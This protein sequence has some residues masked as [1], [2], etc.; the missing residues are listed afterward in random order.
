MNRT[1][2]LTGLAKFPII[3]EHPAVAG[4][5]L[6]EGQIWQQDAFLLHTDGAAGLKLARGLRAER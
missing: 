5:T 2:R 1:L 4:V 3:W 6:V